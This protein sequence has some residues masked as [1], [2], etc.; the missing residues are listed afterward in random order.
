MTRDPQPEH[1]HD[2]VRCADCARSDGA[3]TDLQPTSVV[4]DPGGRPARLPRRR[5]EPADAASADD[6]SSAAAPIG[7]AADL[8]RRAPRAGSRSGTP[9]PPSAATG[10]NTVLVSIYLQGGNDGLNCVVPVDSTNYAAYQAARSNIARLNTASSGGVGRDVGTAGNDAEPRVR[11]AARVVGHRRFKEQ[12]KLARLR[13]AVGDGTADGSDLA[14]FP[15]TDY[16]PP[17]LSHFE[18][19]DYWFAGEIDNNA[20]TG[21]LGRWLDAYGT[22]NNPLQGISIGSD[23]SKSIRTAS[24]PVCTISSLGG[25]GFQIPATGANLN[26]VITQLSGIPVTD[27]NVSLGR[28]RTIWGET[29]Q[30]ANT[31]STIQPGT[32]FSGYPKNSYLADQ[33]QL[34][35]TLLSANLG[36]RVITIDWG[37]FDTHGQEVA[38]QDPQLA[39]LS[40]CLAAFKADLQNRGVE[41]NVVTLAYSEFGR[42]VNS[43]DSGGTDHGAGRLRVRQRLERRRRPGGRA[44]R[45]RP[46][47]PRRQ[48]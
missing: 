38:S 27:G 24:A 5:A 31:V 6:R 3:V 15:A 41:Q 12:R 25:N 48:R 46:R 16:T 44:S 13:H 10:Q 29:V 23:L 40:Q 17:D 20:T 35:A 33:L 8:L 45:G 9:P 1:S 18:S 43:N 21:W 7:F 2:T 42:R 28:A 30:V 14:I 39:E 11:G 19:R 36:T 26:P 32:P 4:S 34:A 22:R 37:S 47:E